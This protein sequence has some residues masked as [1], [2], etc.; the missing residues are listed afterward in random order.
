MNN[1]TTFNWQLV[2]SFL[3]ILQAGSLLGA[4]RMLG[5]SQPTLGRHLQELESQ[6]GV[7]LFERTGR[8]LAPTAAAQ[9]I[10]DAAR[11]MEQGA[12]QLSNSL[13]RTKGVATGTVRITASEPVSCLVLPPVLAQ[14]RLALPQVQ[15]EVLASDA[16]SNLLRREADIAVRM[17]RPEQ[18]SLV[19]RRLALV[20]IGI[21]AHPQYLERRG[22]PS[23]PE[24]LTEHDLVGFDRIDAILRGAR[25]VGH[26]LTREHFVL[27]SDSALVQQA[28]V[29]AGAGLGFL[30]S[31][32]AFACPELVQVLP[33]LRIEPT[34]MWLAVHREIRSSPLIRAV[35][36]FLADALPAVALGRD[37]ATSPE[38]KASTSPHRHR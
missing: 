8:G 37:G 3:A 2:R 25:Q 24:A 28:A 6:L 11:S 33:K 26:I 18:A 34:P 35:F 5:S 10:A 20:P 12:T 15:V 4:A 30:H 29:Q 36:D 7:L 32:Q 17:M 27:R 23:G 19:A 38:P 31:Y 14:M 22:T 9:K 13:L 21:Y 16:V 1:Q